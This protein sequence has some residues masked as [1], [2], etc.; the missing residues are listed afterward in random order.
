[1]C[2]SEER[3]KGWLFHEIQGFRGYDRY[4]LKDVQQ[5]NV[6]ATVEVALVAPRPFDDHPHCLVVNLLR[7]DGEWR[8]AI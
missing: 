1:M 5:G 7:E 6:R 3:A 8:R 4:E 2:G